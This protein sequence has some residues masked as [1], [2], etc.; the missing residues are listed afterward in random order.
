MPIISVLTSLH[1]P[2]V[3]FLDEA[4]ASVESLERLARRGS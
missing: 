3:N 1:A 4:I 2:T